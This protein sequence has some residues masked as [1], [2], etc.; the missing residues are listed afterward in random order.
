M[1]SECTVAWPDDIYN[2][3]IENDKD[4]YGGNWAKVDND[5]TDKG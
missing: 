5:I 1:Q 2:Q 3:T 4:K